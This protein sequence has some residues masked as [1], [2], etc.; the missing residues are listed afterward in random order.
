MVFALEGGLELGK[1]VDSCYDLGQNF[2]LT[3]HPL[4]ILK[5]PYVLLL[6][7]LERKQLS[8]SHMSHQEHTS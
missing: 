2:L 8:T 4:K 3:E 7:L 1:V 5:L 6:H